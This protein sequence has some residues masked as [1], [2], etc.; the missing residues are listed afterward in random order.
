MNE[1]RRTKIV[2]TLGP[3]TNSYDGIKALAIAGVNVFRLNFSHGTHLEHGATIDTI[4]RV[5]RE[6]GVPV[7][8]LQDLCGPKIRTGIIDGD[9]LKFEAGA[10]IVLDPA[11]EISDGTNLPLSYPNLWRDVSVGHKILLAD[12]IVELE[13]I[14]V[15]PPKII[16][17]ALNGGTLSSKKGINYPDG[18]IDLPALTEKDIADLRFG[19]SK[20]VDYVALSFVKHAGDIALARN[21][22]AESNKRVHIV[23]KIEKHE[24][25]A[26]FDEILATVDGV[27]VARGDLGV[28]IPIERLPATQKLLI[29]KA[30][31]LGKPVITATQM[32]LSMVES[33]RPTRAEVTDIANAVLD[34]TDALMLSEE[35]AVGKNPVRAVET[36]AKV[37]VE[38]ER[39]YDFNRSQ[40]PTDAQNE[41]EI[42]IAIA[43][44]AV[45]MAKDM[46]ADVIVC[47]TNSGFT[48][49]NVARFRPRAKIFAP[50]P[51]IKTF[52]RLALV[53]GVIPAAVSI[54]G[55]FESL[56]TRSLR[57]AE[58]SGVVETG[59]EYIFTSGYPF[60]S[61]CATNLIKAGIYK[62]CQSV[63]KEK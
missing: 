14:A 11:L 35:T 55:D 58:Q 22:A 60:G 46:T 63:E 36:M 2:A 21:I 18:T 27:M 6:L 29:A 26:N 61:E 48:A 20:E 33:P 13:I 17:K 56:V 49:R 25:I 23:A 54:E 30:N 57:S 34:G 47:P 3:A 44:S 59:S 1:Y 24:A 51:S 10:T 37:A 40:F 42:P 5:R 8:I 50:T 28:E 45:M 39:I 19:L 43:H 32:L 12:G 4:D 53:W 62:S 7:A 41:L 9:K 15:E 16:C 31:A 52:D 38:I